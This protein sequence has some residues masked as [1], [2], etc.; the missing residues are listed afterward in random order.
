MTGKASFTGPVEAIVHTLRSGGTVLQALAKA[1]ESV[2][3][4]DAVNAATLGAAHN[5]A[6]QITPKEWAGTYYN[7]SAAGLTL[8]MAGFFK[9][10][11]NNKFDMNDIVAF[12][13]LMGATLTHFPFGRKMKIVGAIFNL[14]ALSPAFGELA[15]YLVHDYR[16]NGWWNQAKNWTP[17]RIDPQ[18]RWPGSIRPQQRWRQDRHGL[19]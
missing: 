12:S 4:G 2:S 3:S 7:L 15:A 6:A 9:A 1:Q 17:P 8:S 14:I 19:A 5:L 10:Q 13:A 18:R 16:T 11:Q